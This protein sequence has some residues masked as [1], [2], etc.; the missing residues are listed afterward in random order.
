MPHQ[1]NQLAVPNFQANQTLND[2]YFVRTITT[3]L[4]YGAISVSF[5]G[6]H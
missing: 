6:Y 3:I 1:T 4:V 5:D 2:S